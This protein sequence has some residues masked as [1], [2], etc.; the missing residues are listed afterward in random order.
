[1]QAESYHLYAGAIGDEL[2][3]Q[4]E[5][6]LAIAKPRMQ[7]ALG[8]GYEADEEIRRFLGYLQR[9]D[10][11]TYSTVITVVGEKPR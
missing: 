3:Q 1:M 4:W 5:L 6:K 8:S 7:E 11:F 2:L 9:P 10:T